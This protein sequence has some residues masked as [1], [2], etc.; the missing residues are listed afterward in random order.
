MRRIAAFTLV[1]LLLFS[2]CSFV[3]EINES[4]PT[5]LNVAYAAEYENNWAYACLSAD[6]QANYGAIYTAVRDGFATDDVVTLKASGETYPGIRIKLP[7]PLGTESEI[8][9]LY[10]AFM[11]DNPVFFYIGNA[12]GYGGVMVGGAN[13]YD[14]V[15]L[16]YTMTAA[17]RANA[18]AAFYKERDEL[19][20]LL[21]SSMT[22]FEK[23]L[24]LHDALLA[25]CRY[26]DEAAADMDNEEN[27]N[28]FTAY[29]ALV[30]GDVVCEGYAHAM[31]YLLNQAGIP[32][33]VVIGYDAESGEPHMWNAVSLNGKQYYLDPTW[34]DNDSQIA[35]TFF[36]VTTADLQG[37]HRIGNETLGVP[38]TAET[39][40]NY[41]RM[42]GNYL[43]TLDQKEIAEH[44]AGALTAGER[45]IH[46]RFSPETFEN[47]FFFVQ[48][49][50]WFTE[51]VNACLPVG[52]RPL[53]AYQLIY[54]ENYNTVMICKKTS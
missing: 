29:G 9:Q 21:N 49:A 41:Y 42:T 33:T 18:R 26:N 34:N 36:N 48:N 13:R 15:T 51:T 44:V 7:R 30:E 10:Q 22:V 47:A 24:T 19:L 35:Y 23:E 53:H 14:T 8:Q 12:Y 3:D 28:A 25:R 17:Q 4:P 52:A 46:L 31:Q 5:A 32:A 40:H 37:S 16:T 45:V 1:M 27:F 2:G 43:D 6:Q 11:Q 39:A 50:A 20:G 54:N 38:T